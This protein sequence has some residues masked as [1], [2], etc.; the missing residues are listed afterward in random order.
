MND[1]SEMARKCENL[2]REINFVPG[3]QVD[4]YE[5]Y[6]D[7]LKRLFK[8]TG[9]VIYLINIVRAEKKMYNAYTDLAKKSAE[10][11]FFENQN[12]KTLY[13]YLESSL[14][15]KPA[16]FAEVMIGKV[17]DKIKNKKLKPIEYLYRGGVANKN[18]HFLKSN[19]FFYKFKEEYLGK[20]Y[21][22]SEMLVVDYNLGAIERDFL[23]NSLYELDDNDV[24]SYAI[25]VSCESVYFEK[26]FKYFLESVRLTCRGK[27]D[28]YLS[29]VNMDSSYVRK[30]ITEWSSSLS[31]INVNIISYNVSEDLRIPVSAVAR[32]LSVSRIIEGCNKPVVFCELDGLVV[33][34]FSEIIKKGGE[35]GCDQIVRVIGH[36]MPWN[37]FT[38]GFGVFYPT[39]SGK[40]AAKLVEQYSKG[41]FNHNSKLMWADQV[42]LEGAVRYSNLTDG[43]YKCYYAEAGE[44]KRY[45]FTPTGSGDKKYN[46]ILKKLSFMSNPIQVVGLQ[47]SGTNFLTEILR[48]GQEKR[49]VL[50]TG[51]NIYAWKHA[52]PHE[53]KLTSV[54]CTTVQEAISKE[55][56]LNI[57]LLSKHPLWWLSSIMNRNPADLKKHRPYIYNEN[58]D[59]DAVKAISFYVDFYRAWLASFPEG[60]VFHFRY[61]DFLKDLKAEFLS[62]NNFF[63]IDLDF[64]LN[65]DDLNVKYSKGS[66]SDKKDLYLNGELDIEVSVLE[67][68]MRNIKRE[69]VEFI[70]GMG[71]EMKS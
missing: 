54:S 40:K 33:E 7:L 58:G 44:V 36:M 38:C 8:D 29:T 37:M 48:N 6:I 60:K 28:I 43:G 35:K 68:L 1:S 67:N 63:E 4:V 45:M 20:L 56:G 64:D 21:W 62:L 23:G 22:Q 19:R 13:F 39:V 18:G 30:K 42:A 49:K 15:N 26:Y 34:D 5:E 25:S 51:N 47:R 27:V 65:A 41:I 52:L 57:A 50:E 3:K 66:F 14:A 69:D 59:I 10:T 71:Y 55:E 70:E 11:A 32:L 24:A 9:Q 16:A 46:S 12:E 2:L 31:G 17:F 53:S 61:E